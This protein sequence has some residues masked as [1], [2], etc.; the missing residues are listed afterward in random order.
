MANDRPAENAEMG[1]VK[2]TAT[3]TAT[4]AKIT[5]P[6][7]MLLLALVMTKRVTGD[8]TPNAGS[9]VSY[10]S[11]TLLSLLS[12]LMLVHDP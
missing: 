11:S 6:R 12:L 4:T 3:T 1:A 8:E 10:C 7:V 5:D 2:H 9:T